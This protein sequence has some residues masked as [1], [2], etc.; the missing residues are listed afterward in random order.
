MDSGHI[1]HSHC[2]PTAY[3]CWCPH[4]LQ[5]QISGVMKGLV[6]SIPAYKWLLVLPQLT[7]RLCHQERDVQEFIQTLLGSIVDHFPQQALWSMTVVVKSTVR[8]RQVNWLPVN[9]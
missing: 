2:R 1:E 8:A 4:T 3:C 6:R 7:S 5:L 9:G